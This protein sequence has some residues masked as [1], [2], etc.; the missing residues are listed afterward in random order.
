MARDESGRGFDAMLRSAIGG[1]PGEGSEDAEE[2]PA[3]SGFDQ[4]ARAQPPKK[5]S[6]D[7]Q[8]RDFIDRARG[9]K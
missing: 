2:A 6:A 9:L 5:P 8:I 3:G 4:G 1:D 7:E